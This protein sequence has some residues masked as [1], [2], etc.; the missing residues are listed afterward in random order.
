VKM[1]PDLMRDCTFNGSENT[2]VEA[3]IIHITLIRLFRYLPLL[4]LKYFFSNFVYL[5]T[6][7]VCI[8][9]KKKQTTNM[10][11]S[12]KAFKKTHKTCFLIF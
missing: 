1:D 8:R 3:A 10:L 7:F 9:G 6:I 2:Q 12:I 4:I 11:Y 5:S